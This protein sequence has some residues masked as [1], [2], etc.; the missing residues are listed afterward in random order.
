MKLHGV[1]LKETFQDGNTIY[2]TCNIYFLFY[3][4]NNKLLNI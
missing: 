2:K 1:M 4:I 3:I